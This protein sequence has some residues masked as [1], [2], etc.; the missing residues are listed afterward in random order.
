MRDSLTLF[1]LSALGV[2]GLYFLSPHPAPKISG[3]IAQEASDTLQTGSIVAINGRKFT[4]PWSQWTENNQ[5]R[6]G[7]SDTG[8]MAVLGLN[9]LTTT[10][11]NLQPVTWFTTDSPVK[12]KFANPYRY[13]DLTEVLQQAGA[14]I[15]IADNILTIELPLNQIE[16]IR[17]GNQTWG[18]RLVLDLER[19]T[20]WQVSQTKDEGVVTVEGLANPSLLSQFKPLVTPT[21]S[22]NVDQDD[23]GSANQTE[24]PLFSL[25]NAGSTTKIKIKLPTAQGLQVSSL[26]NPPRLVI[27]VRPDYFPNRQIAWYPGV[28]LTQK[29]INVGAERFPI[30]ILEIDPRL[31]KVSFQPLT[32]RKDTLVG[33]EPLVKI[34]R[35]QGAIIA[36][37]GGFFNRKTQLPLGAMRKQGS[38]LSSPIL[39]R[40]AIAWTPQNQF[41]I[42]RLGWQET[43]TTANGDR[44]PIPLLNSG[45]LQGGMARYTREW[46]ASYT[47]MTD[48]EILL[49]VEN[50]QITQRL[51]G[52]K[53]AEN[54][55]TIPNNGYLLVIRKQ[56]YNPPP[57]GSLVSLSAAT[58]P[59]DF[60]N[61]P[62]ILG[63]GP[64]LVQ[65]RTV[66]LNAE[67][68]NF[69]QPF[70]QQKASRSAI[71][72][73]SQGTILM[74]ALHNRI[75]GTGATL[76]EF[77]QIVQSLGVVE[78]LNLDG[79]SSTSLAL[80]GQL[81]DRS[82]ITAARVH[83]GLGVF[84]GF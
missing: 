62:Q 78:G 48:K 13:L 80:G 16:N 34:S 7:L 56:A 10:N 76:A 28:T 30:S 14:K 59:P 44:Y 9:L 81:I 33:I 77:A 58:N 57:I 50:N 24:S 75:G 6:I 15:Q 22:A 79:G 41:K 37:N 61:Y 63:A 83:N 49:T 3:V 64:V 23:L 1:S 40:A 45:Y 21:P 18:K 25:E 73:T 35:E 69:S 46:G 68:E 67:A 26:A 74:I 53:T 27:D 2:G 12:A 72:T 17:P 71:A 66:V 38:W 4:L 19:P 60:V 31:A 51:Q 52:A 84:L 32:A 39:N 5:P 70:Q 55:V 42:A 36:I 65:N 43:L 20:F 29:V 82:P 54:T 47:T 11:P 8:A